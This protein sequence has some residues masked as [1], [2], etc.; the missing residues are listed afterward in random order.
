MT[1]NELA[2]YLGISQPAV[3][4]WEAGLDEIPVR[5]R[6]QLSDLFL[7]RQDKIHPLIERIARQ[8]Q[9]VTICKPSGLFIRAQRKMLNDSGL[10]ATDVDGHYKQEWFGELGSLESRIA[11]KEDS[12]SG[13]ALFRLFEGDL[14][15]AH[16]GKTYNK[17]RI[18]A[19]HYDVRFDG[20]ERLF[21]ARA[22]QIGTASGKTPKSTTTVRLGDLVV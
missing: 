10:N 11:A 12:E 19:W 14:T 7:N 8:D 5:R 9:T 1:Q 17:I 6:Q 18:K 3:A 2:D 21:V 4:R 22:F 13:P 16:N 20:Y 15:V